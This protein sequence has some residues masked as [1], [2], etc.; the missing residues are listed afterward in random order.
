MDNPVRGCLLAILNGSQQKCLSI[1]QQ[2]YAKFQ[3]WSKYEPLKVCENECMFS[4]RGRFLD[5][6]WIWDT[7]IQCDSKA[8]GIVGEATKKSKQ[9]TIH[10]A[11]KD[12]IAQGVKK[13]QFN[14]TEFRC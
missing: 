14:A 3:V 11:I 7:R 1:F 12:L 6:E 2:T 10:W 9:G 8:P 5:L 4:Q 13:R